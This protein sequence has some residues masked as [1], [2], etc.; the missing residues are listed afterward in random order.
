MQKLLRHSAPFFCYQQAI[1]SIRWRL[2]S[3]SNRRVA[4]EQTLDKPISIRYNYI[5]ITENRGRITGTHIRRLRRV[6]RGIIA[7]DCVLLWR[8]LL[9]Q[10]GDTTCCISA[11]FLLL[12][13]GSTA[14]AAARLVTQLHNHVR[15]NRPA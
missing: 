15:H 8:H 10:S 7:H 14:T 12:Y 9:R 3:T 4:A 1:Q 11:L 5:Y 13:S 2:Y 6:A